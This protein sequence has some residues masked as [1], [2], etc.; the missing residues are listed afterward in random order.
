M[1]A[2]LIAPTS[3]SAIVAGIPLAPENG[4]EIRRRIAVM[5]EWASNP[6]RT[7][8]MELRRIVS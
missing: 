8:G 4:V 7:I 3:G 5:P 6:A 2:T 1:L